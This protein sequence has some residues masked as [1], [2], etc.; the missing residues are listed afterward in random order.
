M[1]ASAALPACFRCDGGGE[2]FFSGIDDQVGARAL[3]QLQPQRVRLADEHPPR[4]AQASQL[5][6]HHADRSGPEHQHEVSGPDAEGPLT[7]QNAGQRLDQRRHGWVQVGPNRHY[8]ALQQGLRR[9][10]HVLSE[11]AVHGQTHGLVV[12]AQ[13]VRARDALAAV[14]AAYVGRYEDALAHRVARD[15]GADLGDD[16]DDFVAGDAYGARREQAMLAVVDAQIR[17]ADAGFL[18]AQ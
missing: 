8:V 17:A 10:A 7:A 16:A 2:V 13:V 3:C 11:A 12:G 9:N 5:D 15:P 14:A 6:V 1:M 18:D 4:T